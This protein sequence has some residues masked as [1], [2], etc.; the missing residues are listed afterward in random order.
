[1]SAK[2]T[3][4][5][6]AAACVLLSAG[7]S[8]GSPA[9]K[10]SPHPRVS[11]S[12][13]A[14]VS[15]AAAQLR[16][17]DWNLFPETDTPA[18]SAPAAIAGAWAGYGV[19]LIPGRH[20]LDG[21]PATPPVRNLTN[22]AVSDADAELWAG[23][24]MRTEAYVGW[25]EAN[26][27]PGF[28]S[29]LRADTFLAGPIGQAVRANQHVND[30]ACDLYPTAIAVVPVDASLDS[31]FASRG[32]HTTAHFALVMTFT[33]GIQP[34]VVTEGTGQGTKVLFT[35][36]PGGGTGI[37]GGLLQHDSLLGDIWHSDAGGECRPGQMPAAC[38]ANQ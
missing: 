20:V 25:M 1:M 21:V 33:T 13:S 24:E 11:G 19:T 26:G 3:R 18:I 32:L 29:R 12:A 36:P 15:F 27:Q 9:G 37:E 5:A 14:S 23:A 31:F 34:C 16:P 28:N 7:C 8:S 2:A 6:A 17:P 4:V 22:G 10:G 35:V 30:P 38:E